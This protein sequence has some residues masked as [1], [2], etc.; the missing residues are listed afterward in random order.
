MFYHYQFWMHKSST[1]HNC[2]H[3]C[4]MSNLSF[5]AH[6]KYINILDIFLLPEMIFLVRK[7][8]RK[9]SL[10]SMYY[11]F[12]SLFAFKYLLY[13]NIENLISIWKIFEKNF[14]MCIFKCHVSF[15]TRSQERR[16]MPWPFFYYSF[17]LVIS[18]PWTI[19]FFSQNSLKLPAGY[20]GNN[21]FKQYNCL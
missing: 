16:I 14:R 5:S 3:I 15:K 17:K 2:N 18:F 8:E 21:S 10:N 12:L 6:F 7:I 13:F 20:S 1:Q 4:I 9:F 11:M 19:C